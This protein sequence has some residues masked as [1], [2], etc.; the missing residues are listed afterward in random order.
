MGLF[1]FN[2]NNGFNF[3]IKNLGPAIKKIFSR[4]EIPK[5]ISDAFDKMDL[6]LN[7]FD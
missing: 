3:D 5:E 4:K 6:K 2:A 7:F 1:N